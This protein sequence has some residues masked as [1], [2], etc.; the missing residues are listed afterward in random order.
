MKKRNPSLARHGAREQG[1]SC[2]RRP[3]QKYASGNAGAD[4]LVFFGIFKK[5]NNFFEFFLRFFQTGHIGKG[6]S[7][8]EISKKMDV[9]PAKGE[10]LVNAGSSL[11]NDKDRKS[12]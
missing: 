5:I 8:S 9:G 10:G 6:D 7:P 11:A 12:V 4:I 1:F 2:A 3:H